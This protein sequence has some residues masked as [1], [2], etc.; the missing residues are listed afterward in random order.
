MAAIA[1]AARAAEARPEPQREP[2]A[3]REVEPQRPTR[4][5]QAQPDGPTADERA[6]LDAAIAAATAQPGPAAPEP[7][8]AQ[9]GARRDR[10]MAGSVVAGV[11]DGIRRNFS[12]IEGALDAASLRVKFELTMSEDGR[13]V[14]QPRIVEPAGALDPQHNALRVRGLLALRKA[15]EQGVFARL[16]RESYDRWS[17]IL[18]TFTPE[19][20]LIL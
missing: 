4:Q 3:P 10:P 1:E 11:R 8:R 13:I 19:E 20:I 17:T 14:G 5:A 2:E 7:A 12:P 9:G 15:D 6:A 16:P 18:V